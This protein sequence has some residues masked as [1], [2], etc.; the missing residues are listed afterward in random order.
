MSYDTLYKIIGLAISENV[1]NTATNNIFVR[2]KY[3]NGYDV[4]EFLMVDND[5]GFPYNQTQNEKD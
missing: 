2:A 1:E 4:Y 5:I 3:C